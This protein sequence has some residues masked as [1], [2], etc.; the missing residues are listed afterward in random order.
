MTI[1]S[2]GPLTRCN[3]R[4]FDGI[5]GA[6]F[7]VISCR[8]CEGTGLRHEKK[9]DEVHLFPYMRQLNYDPPILTRFRQDELQFKPRLALVR[10][11]SRNR[12]RV[13]QVTTTTLSRD[14]PTPLAE[15]SGG[16]DETSSDEVRSAVH[17]GRDDNTFLEG[18]L[19][20]M[21]RNCEANS[22][23]CGKMEISFLRQLWRQ[24]L[25]PHTF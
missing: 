16:S 1:F 10:T 18:K 7:F 25:S 2:I 6:D 14:P 23:D 19:N 22:Y 21:E 12:I 15:W 3:P 11:P 4:L 20:E 17:P 8:A 24:L 9:V 13:L 5:F